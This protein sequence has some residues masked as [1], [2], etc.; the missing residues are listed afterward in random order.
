M[1]LVINVSYDSSINNAPAGYITAIQAAVNYFEQNFT[2]D[3]T[4]NIKFG[5]SALSG[6]ALAQNS[7]YLNYFSYAQMKS[8]L[9][10]SAHSADDATAYA[11]LPA[12]DPTPGG[13]STWALSVGQ[14]KVLGLTPGST[15]FDDYVVLNSSV[16]WTFDPNNRAVAGEYDAIGAIEHEISEGGFGRFGDLNLNGYYT[17]LDL[18]RYSS[19]GVRDF[20]PGHNDYFSIDGTHLLQEFNNHNVYGGDVSDWYPNVQGDSF[21]DGYPGVAGQITPVDSTVL[22]ILGWT[23]A[24]I[25][26]PN[27]KFVGASDFDGNGQAD[28]VW[29]NGGS[30][31]IWVDN[32]NNF[33]Q[34]AISNASMGAEWTADGVGHSAQGTKEIF[35]D[36]GQGG[37]VAVWQVSGTSLVSAAVPGG[38]MGSEWSVVAEGTFSGSGNTDVLWRSASG[39]AA[40]WTMNGENLSGAAVLAPTLQSGSRAIAVGDFFGTG[41][42]SVLWENNSGSLTSWSLSGSTVNGQANVGAIGSEW[43]VA[44]VG[45]FLNDGAVDIV[46]VDTS[47][48]VQIWQMNNGVIS[49]FITPA[50]H[51][52]TEWRLQSVSDFTGDGNSDLLWLRSDGAASLWQINGSSVAASFYGG[53]PSGDTLNLTPPAVATGNAQPHDLLPNL[54]PPVLHQ[55]ADQSTT[56]PVVSLFDHH[57]LV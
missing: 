8:L 15:P 32:G 2:N 9:T 46:W 31:T 51:V 30:A 16:A 19:A 20:S 36:N 45:H 54:P 33:V 17:P 57:L 28:L 27:L 41:H 4:L 21:G 11:S 35:W 5:W 14:E 18:F 40:I 26:G 13:A 23:R 34:Q 55:D 22:D 38:H 39:S 48:N 10:A 1:S 12:S 47:N 24:A 6:N 3:V 44:G 50:G 37:D 53:T 42:D 56:L 25:V 7:F 49:R 29:Q 43:H 52:G